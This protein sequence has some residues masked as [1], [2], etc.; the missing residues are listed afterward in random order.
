MDDARPGW[1][2]DAVQ[3]TYAAAS[4]VACSSATTLVLVQAA[5]F[6]LGIEKESK[7][8]KRKEKRG[9]VREW[10]EIRR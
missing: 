4:E 10:K 7:R 3:K 6:V 8:R 2:I 9:S 1:V 5:R